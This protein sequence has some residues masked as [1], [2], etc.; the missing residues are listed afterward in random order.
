MK[1]A[2]RSGWLHFVLMLLMLAAVLFLS[3]A[4][5]AALRNPA[6]LTGWVLF[7]LLLFL[8]LFNLR[9]KL[10][11]VPMGS[12]SLWMRLH[13]YS[14]LFMLLLFID[15]IGYRLPNGLFEGLLALL[16]VLAALSG[17][18]GA[19]LGRY[20]PVVL[21]Q[22]PEA[23][24]YERL[25][26]LREHIREQVEDRVNRA[27]SELNSDAIAEFYRTQ[28]FDYLSCHR[29]FWRHLFQRAAVYGLWERRFVAMQRYLNAAE[30]QILEEI[31]ELVESKTDLDYQY[32]A[33]SMLKYWLFVHIP[34]SYGLLVFVLL[35]LVLAQ[36]FVWSAG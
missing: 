18:I 9:K 3:S 1:T 6:T 11:F 10:S 7:S 19:L 14:G 2:L 33:R 35:H 23:V 4:Y 15:H 16:Y 24:I 28:L 26:G 13:I 8:L 12:A 32:A 20:L 36:A 25:P 27:V 22:Q 17:I 21:A 30:K 5:A 29:D 31:R 34:L